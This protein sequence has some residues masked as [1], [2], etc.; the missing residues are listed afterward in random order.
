[1]SRRRSRSRSPRSRSRSRSRSPVRRYR[2]RSR[3]RSRSPYRRDRGG[4]DRDYD[5]RERGDRGRDSYGTSSRRGGWRER[6]E[7]Y[8]PTRKS[9]H[10]EAAAQEAARRSRKDCRV[11]VGNL[12]FSVRWGELKD[13]M[14]EGRSAFSWLGQNMWGGCGPEGVQNQKGKRPPELGRTESNAGHG[15]NPKNPVSPPPKGKIVRAAKGGPY[16]DTIAHGWTWRLS[17]CKKRKE[18]VPGGH[19]NGLLTQGHL[20]RVAF[21]LAAGRVVFAEIMQLSDGTSKGC[22]YAF[23]LSRPRAATNL[24]KKT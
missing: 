15:M 16:L 5:Y 11:Y 13:F 4:R 8:D 6:G 20:I 3:S 24:Q 22:G 18:D 19:R 2:S 10:R 9:A 12:S 1:M 14:R 7:P 21:L 17:E 23:S